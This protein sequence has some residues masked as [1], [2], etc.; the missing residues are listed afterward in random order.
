MKKLMIAALMGIAFFTAFA[1]QNANAQNGGGIGGRIK[2]RGTVP[3]G[4]QRSGPTRRYRVYI[5]DVYYNYHIHWGGRVYNKSGRY[6][7]LC[8][9][10]QFVVN[11]LS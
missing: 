8:Q 6:T 9:K 4:Y 1:N 11:L 2:R 5:Y 7:R 3:Y 10:T